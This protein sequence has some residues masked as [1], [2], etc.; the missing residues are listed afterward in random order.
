MLGQGEKLVKVLGGNLGGGG[1]DH[2]MKAHVTVATVNQLS[3]HQ[4]LDPLLLVV[5]Q[6]GN[7]HLD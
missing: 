6:V 1:I 7:F 5:D 4:E 3:V 2:G